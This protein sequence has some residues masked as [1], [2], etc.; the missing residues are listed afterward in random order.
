MKTTGSF[1]AARAASGPRSS[2]TKDSVRS[3]PA[4]TPAEVMIRPSRMKIASRSTCTEG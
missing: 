1:A 2:S 3:M 4:V